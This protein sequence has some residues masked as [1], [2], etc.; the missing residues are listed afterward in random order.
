MS[1]QT[2]VVECR[3]QLKLVGLLLVM[4]DGAEATDGPPTNARIVGSTPFAKLI[5]RSRRRP[6]AAA[7][8]RSS[9]PA[10]RRRRRPLRSPVEIPKG[11]AAISSSGRHRPAARDASTSSR[12]APTRKAYSWHH[13]HSRLTP[14]NCILPTARAAKKCVTGELMQ[15][16]VANYCRHFLCAFARLPIS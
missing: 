7:R 16:S 15:S 13:L 9:L 2:S 5:Q 1:W 11:A 8:T 3:D 14:K 10:W 4:I 6:V 12:S